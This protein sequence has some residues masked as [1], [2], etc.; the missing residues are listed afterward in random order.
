MLMT[1]ATEFLRAVVVAARRADSDL[2]H[3]AARNAAVGVAAHGAR[4]LEDARALRDLAR[5]GF[6][7]E[8]AAPVAETTQTR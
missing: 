2:A 8:P 3:G 1:V 6:G 5:L 7:E 4:R